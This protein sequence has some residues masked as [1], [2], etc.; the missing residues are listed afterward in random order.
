MTNM[1]SN[2]DIDKYN[3]PVRETICNNSVL[4]FDFLFMNTAATVIACYGLLANSS[5]VVIGAMIVAML[6]G[7]ILGCALALV[8]SNTDLLKQALLTL[9]VGVLNIMIVAFIIG[10]AHSD[11]PITDEIIARTAPNILDLMIALSGGAAGAYATVAP[12]L[13]AAFVGVAIATALVPPLSSSSLL[14]ARGEYH[15]AS[16]AFLLAFT[17]IL[18]I[19]LASSTVMWFTGFHRVV[20][21]YKQTE[22]IEIFLKNNVISFVVLLVLSIGLVSNLQGVVSK[23]LFESDVRRVLSKEVSSLSTYNS[24]ADVS[25]ENKSGL[26]IIRAIVRGYKSFTPSQVQAI[27]S[28]LPILS[29]AKN[30]LRVRFIQSTVINRDGI[31]EDAEMNV[32]DKI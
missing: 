14:L 22:Q 17:N 20:R 24:L 12:R 16:G 28:K 8:D 26:L 30:E 27:E 6:L 7:P 4:N 10:L 2:E 5:A 11:I 18:A 19:Q 25:F 13:S 31:L 3:Q 32:T 1:S 15:L 23:Q 29:G 9:L 21:K